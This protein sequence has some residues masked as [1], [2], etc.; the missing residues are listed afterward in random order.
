MIVTV[1][2]SLYP[3]K[4]DFEEDIIAFIRALKSHSQLVVITNAMSTQVKGPLEEVMTILTKE[5]LPIYKKVDT[6]STVLKIVNRD[7]PIEVNALDF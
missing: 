7:L 1:E 3:L 6:C 5:L 2:I 4:T